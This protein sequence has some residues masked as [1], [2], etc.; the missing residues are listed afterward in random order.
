MLFSFKNNLSKY[1][2]GGHYDKAD[3][4]TKAKVAAFNIISPI[5][6]LILV[7]LNVNNGLNDIKPL[8]ELII[9]WSFT[10]ILT[11]SYITFLFYRREQFYS[12][13]LSIAQILYMG[14]L[15]YTGGVNGTAYL[16]FFLV[17]MDLF[18][19]ND[20]KY[21]IMYVAILIF[22]V[23]SI[24]L[25]FDLSHI[26]QKEH[27][28]RFYIVFGVFS[29][30]MA[31]FQAVSR[32]L[33]NVYQF[34]ADELTRN[35]EYLNK[36]IEKQ[37]RLT[38][39]LAI[40]ESE[41]KAIRKDLE[42]IINNTDDL[43]W[44]IDDQGFIKNYNKAFNHLYGQRYDL[45]KN[46]ED[47]VNSNSR[48][49]NDF[50]WIHLWKD[51]FDE[52]F[53]K[54]KSSKVSFVDVDNEE[55]NPKYFKTD[56]FPIVK[57][58]S[59]KGIACF[60]RDIS[61][62]KFTEKNK[63]EAVVSS[64]DAERKRIA[65]DLHDGLGQ[66]LIAANLL[67]QS[68][69]GKVLDKNEKNNL[70]HLL[71][72]AIDETR[73]TSHDLM[74][75]SLDEFGLIPS[76]KSLVNRLSNQDVDIEFVYTVPIDFRF[77]TSIENNLYRVVQ[78]SLSNIIKHSQASKVEIQLVVHDKSIIFT[79][80]DNGVGFSEDESSALGLGLNNIENRVASV[81]GEFVLDTALGRGTNITIEI[82][83]SNG[84]H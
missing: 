76:I 26:Y 38:K 65:S 73:N 15:F 82:P 9:D 13:F 54:G 58:N 74:P 44:Y 34:Q 8:H 18:F 60:S 31:A 29:L 14:E 49:E 52:V 25:I 2:V 4:G 51:R 37:E 12:H 68:M 48:I 17:A 20:I 64:V 7:V 81:D 71:D 45:T 23:S 21:G 63:L 50:G 72:L 5:G 35:N 19:F 80:S 66:T 79:V 24:N 53:E 70:I 47:L 6:I 36:A 57:N 11:V 33:Y 28:V 32:R 61:R 46:I 39:K 69:E 43:I 83:F 27:L 77:D 67:I 59:V 55:N 10:A 75:K 78:E 3:V 40:K 30:I 62:E 22:V 42:A 84:K 41:N 1:L 16:W 56:L